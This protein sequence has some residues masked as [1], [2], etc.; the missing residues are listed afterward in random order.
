MIYHHG[1]R[2]IDDWYEAQRGDQVRLATWLSPG[3]LQVGD[4]PIPELGF[5]GCAFRLIAPMTETPLAANILEPIR[6]SRLGRDIYT[7]QIELVRG[8]GTSR[9]VEGFISPSPRVGLQH[10]RGQGQ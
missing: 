8:G 5:A 4:Q 7:C 2:M 10:V 1:S 9:I 6:A 3:T